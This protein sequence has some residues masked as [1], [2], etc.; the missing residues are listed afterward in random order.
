M[1]R[2]LKFCVIFVCCFGWSQA[3]VFADAVDGSDIVL[4]GPFASSASFPYCSGVVKEVSLYGGQTQVLC[5]YGDDNLLQFG[6]YYDEQGTVRHALSFAGS[7]QFYPVDVCD[8]VWG[9]VYSA[10]S[11]AL[12]RPS[13]N[14][15][16]VFKNFGKNVV[17]QEGIQAFAYTGGSSPLL[18]PNYWSNVSP[19]QLPR[20]FISPNGSW[21]VATRGQ[22]T[23]VVVE[24]ATLSLS[25]IRGYMSGDTVFAIRDDGRALAL[26]GRDTSVWTLVT[27]SGAPQCEYNSYIEST[28]PCAQFELPSLSVYVDH[29]SVYARFFGES[30]S[31]FIQVVDSHGVVRHAMTRL[32]PKPEQANQQSVG[33]LALGDSY[34]SGEGETSDYYYRSHTNTRF[35]RCH[36]STRSYPFLLGALLSMPTRSVACSG[37]RTKDITSSASYSGQNGRLSEAD[38]SLTSSQKKVFEE[39]ALREFIPGRI[40]QSRFIE[41]YSPLIATVGIGGNDAGLMTKLSSC[42]MPSTCSWASSLPN[43]QKAAREIYDLYDRFLETFSEL[44]EA[45]PSSKIIAIGYPSVISEAPLCTSLVGVFLDHT[46]R[47][48]LEESIRYMNQVVRAAAHAAGI[49][50]ASVENAFATRKLCQAGHP[51][52]MNSLRFGDDIGPLKMLPGLKVIGAESFHPTPYGQQLVATILSDY[53]L[54]DS[55]Q[56]CYGCNGPVTR[57]PPSYW[58]APVD[59]L[60]APQMISQDDMTVAM[61]EPGETISLNVRQGIFRPGSTVMVEIDAAKQQQIQLAVDDSGR[62][63]GSTTLLSMV[64]PGFYTIFIHGVS[65]TDEDVAVYQGIYIQDEKQGITVRGS[66]EQEQPPAAAAVASYGEAYVLGAQYSGATGTPARTTTKNVSEESDVPRITPV[67]F[68]A[69]VTTS[70]LLIFLATRYLATRYNDS[71]NIRRIVKKL[72]PTSLFSKIEPTGHLIEAVAANIRYGFPGRKLHIIG[73]TGTNGKTTTAFLIHRMLH[74]AGVPV[75]I[76]TTVGYGV[77]SDITSQQEHITTAQAGVLQRR[78]RDFARAGAQ[79]VVVET[80]SHSLAQHRVWGV[81]YEIAVMTNVTHDHIDYHKTFARY[82]DAKRRLF[83]IADKHGL[84]FGVINADDPSAGRFKSAIKNSVTYGLDKGSLR[85]SDISLQ[86]DNSSF[87]A[88]VGEDAYALR[89]NIPGEFNVSNA[90]AAVA[91]GRELEL[92]KDDIEKG[93]AALQEVE[94][95]MNV[96][97]EGQPFKVIIDF[98]STPDGFEKFFLSVRPLTKG[99]LIAVFGSAGRR[100]KKKRATQGEIAGEYADIV[101]ATEEDD[102]DEPGADILQE[103]VRGAKKAGKKEGKNVYVE[104]SREKA[105]GFAFT[106]ATSPNDVVV[107]LGKG[108]EKTIERADGEYPWSENDVARSALRA[109]L[110][111]AHSQN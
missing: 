84:R 60:M 89:V 50:F 10:S 24:V 43:R 21:M 78:L 42:A 97:D 55:D 38:W 45:S 110:A 54:M 46:E 28:G 95:R 34:S 80:S 99:K 90:L 81:P 92:T 108:H 52:A 3:S 58:G 30:D 85:A 68:G 101:V 16:S 13:L 5:A 22:A 103:I 111:E 25:A 37:A 36:Q 102:R 48:Y 72:I 41:A 79:W 98:A 63:Q 83:S 75:A 105:I 74:E 91:V 93:I 86:A 62:V 56:S 4:T 31:L 96:I 9:C 87:T 88:R 57:Q 109:M 27:P 64:E 1:M 40:P 2:L 12:F 53:S 20:L 32:R 76:T 39:E 104:P 51:A 69:I 73:V 11:D 26:V 77:G 61:A 8:A 15:I 29:S 71:M 66:E 18:T 65:R 19:K 14:G 6:S 17:W 44:R 82:R 70:L 47:Q 35:E 33:Y 23:F 59:I 7:T 94:G 107:L 100:D 49:E 67:F 106:L